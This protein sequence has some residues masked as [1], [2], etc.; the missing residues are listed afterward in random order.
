MRKT[1]GH[2]FLDHPRDAGETYAEHA[3][4]ASR[5]GWRLMKA[6]LCAFTHAVIPALHKT[7]ASD[8]VRQMAAELNGRALTARE[9]RMHRAGVYDPGL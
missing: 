9:A 1:F 8:T 2:L 7:T 3:G 4:V 6:A 5:F